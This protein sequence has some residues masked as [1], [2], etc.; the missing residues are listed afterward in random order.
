MAAAMESFSI[1]EY[2]A[3]M[4][5]VDYERCWPFA[6]ERAE[7]SLPP[8]P[9]RKFRWWVEE[10]RAVPSGGKKDGE[11]DDVVEPEEKA[12]VDVATGVPVVESTGVGRAGG[13]NVP[14]EQRQAK[15]LPSKP[16]P[17][18]PK[19]RSILELFAVA[20]PVRGG[21]QEQDLRD[22]AGGKLQ[23]QGEEAAGAK[24]NLGVE[25]GGVLVEMRKRKKRVKDGEKMPREKIGAN[26]KWKT[27]AK[28]TNK[29]KKLNV[30]IRAAKK[31]NCKLKISSLVDM[32]K[33]LKSKRYEKKFGKMHNRLVCN[34]AKPAT[35]RTLLKKHIF[36][37]VQ[38]SKLISRNQEAARAPPVHS[39]FK[40]RKRGTSTKKRKAIENKKGSDLVEHCCESAKQ[41]SFSGKNGKLVHG[42]SC[43]PLKLPHLQ[44]L[45]KMVSDVLAASSTMDNLNK[46]PSVTEGAHW[47]LNDTEGQLNLNDNG[48]VASN[49]E[50]S[51]ASSEEQLDGT[52]DHPTPSNSSV[53]KRSPLAELVDLNH[54]VK[55]HV[56]LNS[57]GLD[58]S[59]MTPT[60]M[61]SGD[62][63]VP[64]PM[65]KCAL[66]SDPGTSQIHSFSP[67]FNHTN[68]LHNPGNAVSVSDTKSALSL[69]RKQDQH[70]WVSCLDQSYLD[71]IYMQTRMMDP[72]NNTCIG[73]PEYRSMYHIPKDMLIS[74]HSSVGS[75]A[76]V[77]PSPGL[78]PIWRVNDTEEG[79]IGLPLNSQGELIELNPG[80]RY[81]FCE[82]DE[83][84]NSALNSLQILPSSTHFQPQSSH[85]RMKGKYP[86]VSSYHDDEQ[87]WF[88]K[89][90]YPARKLVISESGSVA[91]QG[92]EKVR[93]Q[94]HDGRPQLYHCNARQV[95]LFCSRC[96]DHLVTENC[97]DRMRLYS[98]KDMEQGSRPA[99]QPT[100]RLMGKNVTVGSCSKEHQGCN[101]KDW[102]DK[103]MVTTSNPTIREHDR[104]ILKRWHEEECFRQEEYE[105]S[106]NIPFSS[107]DVPSDNCHASADKLTS[108]HM[109]HGFGPNWMLNYGNPSSRGEHGIHI[110]FSQCPVPCQSFQNRASH[111]AV[112]STTQAQSVDMGRSKTLRASHPRNFCQ[113]MLINSTHCKHSQNVSYGIPSTTHPY[114]N[115]VP[116]QTSS[117]HSLQ[118]FPHWLLN[119]TNQHPFVPYHPS[120][121]CQSCMIPANRGFPHSSPYTKSVIAFPSG[122]SNSSQ[123]Y[124]SYTP[125]SVV[126]PSSTAT[127]TNNFSSASS[128]YGDNSKT[129]DG[130]QFNFAHVK[131]QDHSK[132]FRKRSAAKDD[133]IVERVKRPNL[134]LQEDLNAPTS[135]RREGLNGD[136]K[137]N[138]REPEV[139]VCVSRT[140]D[141][142]LPVIDDGRDSVAIS[143]GS[144]PLKSSHLRPGPVKLS[145]G[146]KHILRPNG[147]ID[148]EN[149][150]PIHST[151]PFTQEASAA[152]DGSQEKAAKVYRF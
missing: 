22:G 10:L 15:N 140:V 151:V 34:Q 113:H 100:M 91:L 63:K 146:A 50:T 41:L 112:H 141:V 48:V 55:D 12:A 61:F 1:R 37:F 33:I 138:I 6:E 29:K 126:Y 26:K 123:T 101:D 104:P 65:N 119:A 20:P 28:M 142:C 103:E 96:K 31:E 68:H 4:R 135:L 136:Q 57:I 149:F 54:P 18:T 147:S 62:L 75:K 32:S 5:N 124:G 84:P 106:R 36:R 98:E 144:L 23:P 21:V 56:D 111:S 79:F 114:I 70:H 139:N 87:N 145:A 60:P 107:L 3:R 122:N 67:I 58:G 71:S 74:N 134:K 77:E 14:A 150:R 66:A 94:S 25:D 92:V 46:C 109:H 108:N 42:R 49:G 120:A 83:M 8:M 143:D 89:Q 69:T 53:T 152:K 116:V 64:G 90:H 16:K 76:T 93:C 43:L 9:V 24:T 125:M 110:D 11:A 129:T 117:G 118:R 137:D 17:R 85:V 131:C 80:T 128:T 105:A 13:G 81:G 115:H 38:T 45:C 52:F 27:K 86:F 133:K 72:R 19:K 95:E 99:I 59:T 2:A 73:F 39:I 102:T 127:L 44:T 40:K 78:G 132:R 121:A 7:R 148:Q 51:E 30:E 97:F 130:M 47:N 88:L 82:V 35:I